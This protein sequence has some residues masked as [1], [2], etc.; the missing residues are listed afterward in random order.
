M[1][2]N[3]EIPPPPRPAEY[4]GMDKSTGTVLIAVGVVLVVLGLILLANPF[5]AIWIL[6]VLI[7]ASFILG[8]IAEVFSARQSGGPQWL[9]WVLGG[10]FVALGLAAAAWPDAT[11]WVL[12]FLGGLALVIGG[13][14]T[15]AATVLGSSEGR[16]PGLALGVGTFVIG[17]I[18]LAWPDATL[19]VVAILI[20]LRTVL[21]GALAIGVGY[22]VRRLG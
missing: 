11:V 5:A 4:E 21:A 22:N 8:G 17:V 12:A 7:G 15:I 9:S 14:A 2:E 20:G 3:I 13:I 10:V 16:G 6:G 18:V 19:L 1:S